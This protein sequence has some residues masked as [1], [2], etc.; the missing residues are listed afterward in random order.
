MTENNNK[1]DE[2]LLELTEK[3]PDLVVLEEIKLPIASTLKVN[4]ALFCKSVAKNKLS[5]TNY[6]DQVQLGGRWMP[7]FPAATTEKEEQYI[8]KMIARDKK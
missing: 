8:Q 7:A 1:S 2:L 5:N 4:A 3:E 6:V